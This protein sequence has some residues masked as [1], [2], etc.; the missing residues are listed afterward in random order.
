MWRDNLFFFSSRRR[1]TRYW[2]DWSSDVCSSDLYL[3]PCGVANH[4]PHVFPIG[5]DRAAGFLTTYRRECCAH[6]HVPFFVFIT[7]SW[8]R[9]A[10]VLPGVSLE[11]GRVRSSRR[12]RAA[13]SGFCASR[14]RV[15]E[16]RTHA[17]A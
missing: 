16:A 8:K 2:R 6:E 4:V 1:H 10:T 9:L 14:D 17:L 7:A 13:S 12:R 3:L 11:A 15:I 5:P